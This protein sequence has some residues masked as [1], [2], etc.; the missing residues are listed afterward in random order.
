M[1]VAQLSALALILFV[2]DAGVTVWRRGDRQ[3]ALLVS[4]SIVFFVVGALFQSMLV[5]WGV[6]PGPILVSVFYVG[7]VAAMGFEL[8]RDVLRAAELSDELRESE[9]RRLTKSA[10]RAG[11]V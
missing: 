7:V 1:L 9:E 11:A 6:I 5:F 2:A 4:G 3:K 10:I 8:S